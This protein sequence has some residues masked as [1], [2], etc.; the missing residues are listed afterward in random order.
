MSKLR[1]APAHCRC[2]H[3]EGL[4]HSAPHIGCPA[5]AWQSIRL[6][7]LE[8]SKGRY[9][10]PPLEASITKKI[11]V[12][13]FRAQPTA[14]CGTAAVRPSLT[15]VGAD[16]FPRPNTDVF[17][18]PTSLFSTDLFRFLPLTANQQ[19]VAAKQLCALPPGRLRPLLPALGDRVGDALKLARS[20]KRGKVNASRLAS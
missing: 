10:L 20:L 12:R 1:R 16:C 13:M 14:G 17:R 2:A 6:C 7:L 9:S 15:A 19:L 4:A 11:P 3:A 18:S 5:N 8:C